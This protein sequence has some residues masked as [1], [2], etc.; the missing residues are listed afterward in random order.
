MDA[1]EELVLDAFDCQ[2]NRGVFCG[3]AVQQQNVYVN[4][5]E[6]L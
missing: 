3:H 5:E 2:L 4:L 1:N 6:V